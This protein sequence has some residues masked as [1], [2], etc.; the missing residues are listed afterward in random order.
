MR[1]GLPARLRGLSGRHSRLTGGSGSGAVGWS[2]SVL[3]SDQPL[4]RPAPPSA[5]FVRRARVQL[6]P[7]PSPSQAA[8]GT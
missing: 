7:S 3:D 5:G 2:L 4:W 6:T 1:S 8:N